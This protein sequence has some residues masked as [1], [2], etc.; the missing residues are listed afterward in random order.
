MFY[1]IE[2]ELLSLRGR[3]W[4]RR[5]EPSPNRGNHLRVGGRIEMERDLPTKRSLKRVCRPKE[6]GELLCLKLTNS[7]IYWALN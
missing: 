6:A 4:E 2:S 1:L 5:T 7:N 3:Q